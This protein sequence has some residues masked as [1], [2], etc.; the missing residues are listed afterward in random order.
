MFIF[1]L[2]IPGESVLGNGSFFGD[3][4]TAPVPISSSADQTQDLTTVTL[5]A[6]HNAQVIAWLHLDKF[7]RNGFAQAR[8]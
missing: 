2:V 1:P 6:Q 3:E 7:M 4:V 5:P 8:N